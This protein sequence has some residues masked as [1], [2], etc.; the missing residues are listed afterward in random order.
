MS[1]NKQGTNNIED[2]IKVSNTFKTYEQMYESLINNDFSFL[3]REL[4]TNRYPEIEWMIEYF[5]NN[6]EYEKCDFLSKLELPKVMEE[7]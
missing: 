4:G 6:E 1:N 5:E 3:S 7:N 2:L